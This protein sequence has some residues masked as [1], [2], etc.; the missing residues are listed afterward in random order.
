MFL[1]I[2]VNSLFSRFLY[3]LCPAHQFLIYLFILR[4]IC[5]VMRHLSLDGAVR[6]IMLYEEGKSL[7]YIANL[8]GVLYGYKSH[9][10]AHRDQES[11]K[12]ARFRLY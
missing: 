2:D 7:R 8:V 10:K 4:F 3:F 11:R 6:I 5:I 12:T 9:K 1:F